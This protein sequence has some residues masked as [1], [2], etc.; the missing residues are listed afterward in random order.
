MFNGNTNRHKRLS[1]FGEISRKAKNVGRV[2]SFLTREQLDFID[3]IGKDAL[4]ASGKKLSRNDVI[5]AIVEAAK[6]LDLTGK[7]V[8]SAEE[9]EEKISGIAKE[10][11]SELSKD[12]KQGTKDEKTHEQKQGKKNEDF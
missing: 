1:R 4:F 3:R 2:V 12:E 7:G 5:R 11:L 8:S 6:K 10:K 9:L